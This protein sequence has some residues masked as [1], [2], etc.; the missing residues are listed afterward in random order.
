MTYKFKK[1]PQT[2]TKTYATSLDSWQTSL[3][4][5]TPSHLPDIFAVQEP[6]KI[7]LNSQGSDRYMVAG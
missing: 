2:K 5:P 4:P 6:G 3:S 1:A 7:I